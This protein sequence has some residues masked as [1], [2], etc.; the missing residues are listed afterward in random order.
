MFA[1]HGIARGAALE[2]LRSSQRGEIVDV[3]LSP[4][5]AQPFC[6][7]AMPVEK[8]ESADEYIVRR[9]EIGIF[10]SLIGGCVAPSATTPKVLAAWTS[11]EHE[12]L[13][14]LRERARDDCYVR[15]WLQ[16]GRVPELTDSAI[17]DLRYGDAGS[18]GFAEMKLRPLAESRVCPRFF[19]NWSMPRADLLAPPQK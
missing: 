2:S 12:S 6:W 14:R 15:A 19:T 8:I 1:L 3:V 10:P 9:G 16:F 11:E 18:G 5:A 17:T 13:S 7:T 4:R